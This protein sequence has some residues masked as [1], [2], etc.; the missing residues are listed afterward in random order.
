MPKKNS[1]S[2]KYWQESSSD[3]EDK[4]GCSCGCPCPRIPGKCGIVLKD[5]KPVCHCDSCGGTCGGLCASSD[6]ALHDNEDYCEDC[7]NKEPGVEA[8]VKCTCCAR[9]H[10]SKGDIMFKDDLLSYDSNVDTEEKATA[11]RKAES[12]AKRDAKRDAKKAK[13][14]TAAQKRV[15]AKEAKQVPRVA[16]VTVDLTLSSDEDVGV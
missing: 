2:G 4:Q 1:P 10:N 16:A 5:G 3:E 8:C 12:K 13:K 9:I 15:D 6:P 7:Y 11:K 14:E